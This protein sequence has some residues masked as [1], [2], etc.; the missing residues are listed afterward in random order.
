[1]TQ[2]GRQPKCNANLE[3]AVGGAADQQPAGEDK[4]GVDVTLMPPKDVESL[5]RFDSVGADCVVKGRR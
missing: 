4:G 5:A 1:M 2:N 3:S